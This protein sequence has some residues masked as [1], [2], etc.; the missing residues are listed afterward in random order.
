MSFICLVSSARSPGNYRDLDI[1]NY[2]YVGG[3]KG[4]HTYSNASVFSII[5][6]LSLGQGPPHLSSVLLLQLAL[7]C[8]IVSLKKPLLKFF[9]ARFHLL[10][11]LHTYNT[12]Q[13]YNAR[14]VTPKCEFKSFLFSW[15]L[16]HWGAPLISFYCEWR[17]I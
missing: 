2:I 5:I 14:K 4:T 16:L 12:N 13:I 8:E 17:R 15:G 3:F 11:V 9:L 10:L 7:S 6:F 1:D